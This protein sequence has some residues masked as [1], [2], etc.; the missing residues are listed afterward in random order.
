MID[1][2]P[3]TSFSPAA[4][5]SVPDC[6]HWLAVRGSTQYLIVLVVDQVIRALPVVST[7]TDGGSLP[8]AA[9]RFSAGPAAR[10][11]PVAINISRTA[12]APIRISARCGAVE[13]TSCPSPF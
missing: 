8:T 5:V 4:G 6:E 7:A 12:S 13:C 1:C 9:P 2:T 11:D 3:P 10:A